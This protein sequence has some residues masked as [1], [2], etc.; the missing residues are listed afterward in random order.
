MILQK[1]KPN[2]FLAFSRRLFSH[3]LKHKIIRF[4]NWF[5][6]K[7]NRLVLKPEC[8]YFQCEFNLQCTKQFLNIAAQQHR[9]VKGYWFFQSPLSVP[10]STTF[11]NAAISS[12]R[13]LISSITLFQIQILLSFYMLVK[14]VRQ[15]C[16]I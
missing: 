5:K 6:M 4:K 2:D 16:H 14:I 3:L 1:Y 7:T 13:M 9:K 8:R 15:N 11:F 10:A 12:L